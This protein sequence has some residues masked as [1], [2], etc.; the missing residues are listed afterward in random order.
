MQ[1]RAILVGVA[2]LVLGSGMVL[3]SGTD[4]PE[5]P[6][7][8][9]HELMEDVGANAKKLGKALKE[10]DRG[11]VLATA[12]ALHEAAGKVLPLFP[13]GSTHPESRSL[14]KIWTDWAGFEAANQKFVDST[15]AL[16]NAA[17]GSESMDAQGKAVFDS[18]KGCHDSYRKPED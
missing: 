11:T 2:S 5:G 4:L 13:K 16:A 8:D 14:D 17:V 1:K 10:K 12:K 15:L 7:R 3:A 9:R 6:I 18:C